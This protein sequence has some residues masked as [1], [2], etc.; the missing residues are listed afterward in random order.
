MLLDTH[1]WVWWLTSAPRMPPAERSALDDLASTGDLRLSAISLWEAQMLRA[2]GRLELPLPFPEWL[3]RATD[4]RMLSVM[5]L[6]VGVVLA[7]ND[8]PAGF[9]GDPAD[10]LIVATARAHKLTLATH[11]AVIRRSRAVRVWSPKQPRA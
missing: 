2:R 8:L 4:H 11:D 1:V 6:D 3:R 7:L 10:R 5:P 9:H